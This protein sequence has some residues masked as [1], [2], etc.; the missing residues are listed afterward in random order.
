MLAL[1]D[2]QEL[3]VIII[4]TLHTICRSAKFC[5]GTF[6]FFEKCMKFNVYEH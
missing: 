3:L 5:E 6:N 1:Y 4:M 2:I